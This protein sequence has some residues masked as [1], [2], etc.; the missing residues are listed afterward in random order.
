MR[1]GGRPAQ[2]DILRQRPGRQDGSSVAQLRGILPESR[3]RSFLL[4]Q[5][6]PD[7]HL[8]PSHIPDRRA[9]ATQLETVSGLITS[10][11]SHGLRGNRR[12]GDSQALTIFD[13]Q[14]AKGRLPS[15]RAIF[16]R[17][18]SLSTLRLA[19]TDFKRRFSS[20]STATSRLFIPASPLTRKRSRHWINVAT[21]TRYLRD[22]A[23]RSAPRSSSRMTDV[24]RLADQRPPAADDSGACSVALRAPCAAPESCLFPVDMG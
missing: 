17:R 5:G 2:L 23:S 24:L 21:V 19:T 4:A 1:D 10:W 7:P 14:K 13:F 16:S 9:S 20:S 18:S 3:R 6:R 11:I 12:S 22:V 8:P 15:I